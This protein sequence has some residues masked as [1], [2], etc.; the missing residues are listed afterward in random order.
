MFQSLE[1][2]ILDAFFCRR[3]SLESSAWEG[4]SPLTESGSAPL[5]FIRSAPLHP[6]RS[7]SSAPLRSTALHPL[8]PLHFRDESRYEACNAAVC[9][10]EGRT[11]VFVRC[12]S[13]IY[14]HVINIY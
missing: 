11:H 6:L 2:L 7:A 5:R 4:K 12:L 10:V 8:H 13:R 14:S 1:N 9:S 3:G